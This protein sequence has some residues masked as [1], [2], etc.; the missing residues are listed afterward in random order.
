MAVQIGRGPIT[1]DRSDTEVEP[2]AAL[3]DPSVPTARLSAAA[4]R[5][6]EEAAPDPAVGTGKFTE[7]AR[8]RLEETA[9]QRRLRRFGEEVAAARI[10]RKMTQ[11]DLSSRLLDGAQ[12]QSRVSRWEHGE[13]EPP[14]SVVFQIE[15]VLDVQ[16]GA[17]SRFLGYVPAGDRP[18]TIDEFIEQDPFLE[19]DEKD[20]LVRI[21]KTFRNRHYHR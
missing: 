14:P 11:A 8:R 15:R 13:V 5:K 19:M 6:L 20:A 3:V 9:E 16:P 1:T 4:R 17:L 10:Q 18:S 2:D 21:L 12:A 7:A